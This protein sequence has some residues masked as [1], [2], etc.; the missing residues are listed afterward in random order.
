MKRFTILA[1]LAAMLMPLLSNAQS[2]DC[3]DYASVPYSTGFEGISTGS[4]P[5]CW[6]QYQTSAGYDGVTF[7]CAYNYA[8]NA[9]NGNVYFE[10]ET[11]SGQNEVVAMPRMQNISSLALTFWVS[12][13]SYYLPVRFEVGVM[14]ETAT[15]T[16]FVPVDTITFTT[17]T[18]WSTGYNQYTVYFA[19][20]SGSG[21]RIAFRATGS[22]SGQYT[23]MMDDF[24]VDEFT[25]CYPL[26]NLAA[27]DIDSASITLQWND[28]LNSIASYTLSYWT[29][30]GDTTVVSGISG[31][32][33]TVSDLTPV[34]Q[35]H[36]MV[37]P[38]CGSGDGTPVTASF[39]TSCAALT[40]PFTDDFENASTMDCWTMVNIGSSGRMT[41]STMSGNACFR[42]FYTTNPPQ[43]LVSP[44]LEG[45]DNGASVEF[46]YKEY[47]SAYGNET[48]HVGYSTTS[49]DTSAFTWGPQITAST[50]T[51][52]YAGLVPA[53]T[54]YVAIKYTAYDAYYLYIDNIHIYE[55]N[56][57]GKPTVTS[58]ANV[59]AHT[60]DL[61]WNAVSSASSYVVTYGTVNNIDNANNT[62]VNVSDTSYT[63]SGLDGET[64]YYAWVA[65]DCGS[66][67]SD[68]RPFSSFQT[69]VSCPGVGNIT[70]DS[71]TSDGATISWHAG[72]QETSW[73]V[74]VDSSEYETVYDTSYTVTGLDPMTGHTFHVRADCGGDDGLS[75]VNSVNFTTGCANGSCNITVQMADTY[76]DGWNGNA[77]I[78]FF[79]NGTEAGFA[80][81][82]SG[83][84]GSASVSVCPGMPV[85]FS[86]Q[87][88]SWDTEVSYT[89]YDGSGAEV[90]NSANGGVNHSDT[91]A[92]ACPSCPTPTGVRATSVDSASITFAW[93]ED[94]N[95]SEY[96]ISFNG[97]AYTSGFSG[98]ETY[99]GLSSNTAYTFSVRAVCQAGVDTSA[100]STVTAKTSCGSM[101]LPLVEGFEAET[102]NAA[103]LCWNSL[104]GNPIVVSNSS[105]AHSGT[106]ALLLDQNNM[107]A[108]SEVPLAGDSIKVSFWAN[109]Y[110]GT[111][112]A[113]VMTNVLADSTFIPLLTL[114][115]TSG[116]E[117]FEFNTATQPHDSSYHV[118]FRF[119]S[120]Y[121]Y[122]SAYIDDINITED[123]G[124]MHPSA[125]VATPVA[126]GVDLSWN[127]S[128]ST[129]S[130]AIE[131]R[132]GNGAWSAPQN[133]TTTMASLSGLDAS[134]SYEVRVGAVCGTDTLWTTT[135]FQTPCGLL[136]VPYDEDFDAYA[137][138][139]MPPCWEWSS[140][141][142][143]HWDG[144]VFLKA[145]HG[146]GSEYV[147][148]PQLDGNIGKL[149]I[150]FDTKVGSPAEQDGILIGVT[151]AAGTLLAW[152]DTI[153]DAN[154]SRNNH[155]RKTVY[156]T[157]YI[158]PSGAARVAFAQY[159]NWNEW[160]LI[161]NINIE[162]LPDC[163]P[164]DN[165]VGHNLEDVES[166]TFTWT[167]QG[168]ATQWQVYVDTVSVDI[169]SLESL[170]A[171]SFIDV[172]TTAY[173]IPIGI[174]QG[175]G[176]YNF[177]VR[178]N[179]GDSY[180]NW[181]KN[182]FGA[183][184]IVMNN[185]GVA[186]TFTG[187]GF[188]VY[189]N[190]GPIAGYLPNS[191]SAL[192][193]RTE[194]VG[195][196]L[197]IFGGK[198][199]FG[200]DAATLTVY[201]GEGTDGTVLY[202]YNTTDGRDT[203]LGTVLATSTTGSLTI[204]F[205][206]SGNM[207]HTG[208]ELYVR[209]T[210]GAL[211]PRP[212][213]LQAT[214]TSASEA[215]ATWEGTASNYNFYYRLHNA[216]TWVR[217]PTTTNS[218]SLVGLMAD[219]IYDMY[220]IAICSATD[221]SSAS[222]V[223]Q[224]HTNYA[225]PLPTHYT[226]TV[227]SDNEEMGTV[228]GGG[229][230]EEGSQV[231][232]TA[233]PNAGF[234]FVRWND[235]VTDSVRTVTVTADITYTA[236]FEAHGGIDDVYGSRI[237]LFPN[238][239]STTVT[240]TGIEGQATVTVVDIDGRVS[241]EWRTANGEL[242]IDVSSL[243]QG[244]YFVR[245]VGE[246]TNAVRKLIVR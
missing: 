188:V 242:T 84:A 235:N 35:Y 44:R 165:L 202:T 34:T 125:L 131:Y 66:A 76:G 181:V 158:M 186:D 18:N 184:S 194:N 212:T 170:P 193:L 51:Q 52:S 96:I 213:Q 68:A 95:V 205:V 175:G 141:F 75:I 54:K 191:N 182:E 190:G 241:G 139:V 207:C 225:I 226:V 121:S 85:A 156:F 153:Q 77:Q 206:S 5:S 244:T 101:A 57:C 17:S 73:L 124:C 114:T 119:A 216:A 26:T 149:K 24:S 223:R 137:N 43:Y 10:F 203:L 61:S 201:D 174:I 16:V 222:V 64:T 63:L 31:S 105:N 72:G 145:Y 60:A 22:G 230:Y 30:G 154:F 123:E 142:A 245:I 70:V 12:A 120:S 147:V 238:P 183:G 172:D 91:I 195:S 129:N 88:G 135:T 87:P 23:L 11:H 236:Y 36:F 161:D 199:G 221:S 27:A 89:I 97:S 171:T 116:Y 200:S 82:Y 215:T 20:Y 138:D 7:P 130:F 100:A 39:T 65:S 90:Y 220:V 219:T 180:S 157:N 9:R 176:I 155:V 62:T 211:C 246:Q 232:L 45:V 78:N 110:G 42:F 173:T 50:S 99:S 228:S 3:T 185:T 4:L 209:C 233:T 164:V 169:D 117:L 25:G 80:K 192:V 59:T 163:Y 143:T 74:A 177:F 144:G 218:V 81:L 113:G 109:F 178:S 146:G 38:N 167:P 204:T 33:Y 240:L 69:L 148:L 239:A 196:Q 56:G 21:E 111:L 53:G 160:A 151:D 37:T 32:S 128:G 49:S 107:I 224:L 102:P 140:T 189:D 243:A 214:M 94:P 237:A 106:N 8:G 47:S 104:S 6:V 79:Q 231:T 168:F 83:S 41:S 162:E 71:T 19:N 217:I 127:Y 14:E 150:E 229:I 28:Q 46:D 136:P 198:F 126:N 197:Q 2:T 208:Y 227:V 15:D 103:P 234:F 48:F 1:V 67:T 55:D 29:T 108:T 134:T 118:A 112:E 58:V 179:C 152:L 133:A 86:W 159:R 93:N 122:M 98:T 210:D 187:C 166:T 40:L 92:N 13:Q 132:S 115:T